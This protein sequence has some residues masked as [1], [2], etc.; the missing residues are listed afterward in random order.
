MIHHVRYMKRLAI[1]RLFFRILC[2]VTRESSQ[3]SVVCG[4]RECV[5]GTLCDDELGTLRSTP[6]NVYHP[7]KYRA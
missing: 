7:E 2:G 4:K 6:V 5:T 1:W 3:F